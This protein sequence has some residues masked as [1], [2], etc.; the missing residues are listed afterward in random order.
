MCGGEGTRLDTET[1]KPLYEIVGRPMV[2]YVLDA[3]IESTVETVHAVTSPATPA[4]RRHLSSLTADSSEFQ[5]RQAPGDGYVTD[6]NYALADIDTPVLTATADVP[7]VDC[8]AVDTVLDQYTGTSLTV[9]VPASLKRSLG[10]SSDTS[11][12][13]DGETVAPTGVNI[14]GRTETDDVFITDDA[15]F[16][17]N[18]NYR[19]DAHIAEVLV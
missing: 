14:V 13:H 17:V 3:L 11:M 8:D 16:A 1:E 18:V 10:V 19:R 7:L 12:D 9:C 6:L 2:E 5:H 15:R 4:T